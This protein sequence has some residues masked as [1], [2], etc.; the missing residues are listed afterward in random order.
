VA[1]NNKLI[2]NNP[3]LRVISEFS[4]A[5]KKGAAQGKASNI[6]MNAE[7]S[8]NSRRCRRWLL[9]VEQLSPTAQRSGVR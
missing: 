9:V 1:D 7:P 8:Q 6:K 5:M 2:S 4:Q 3:D